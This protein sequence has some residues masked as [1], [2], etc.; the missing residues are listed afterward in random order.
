MWD[1]HAINVLWRVFGISLTWI[2][3]CCTGPSVLKHLTFFEIMTNIHYHD[4]V[5]WVSASR[6]C[7]SAWTWPGL[8]QRMQESI[9]F[10]FFHFFWLFVESY[11]GWQPWKR[12]ETEISLNIVNH[13]HNH[14]HSLCSGSGGRHQSIWVEQSNGTTDCCWSMTCLDPSRIDTRGLWINM[15]KK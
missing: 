11:A 4:C 15:V 9:Q 5:G 10:I 8:V 7:L 12:E 3:D 6:V 13:I 14:Y 2:D 1:L